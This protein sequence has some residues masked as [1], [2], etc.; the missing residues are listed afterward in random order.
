M[1]AN[2]RMKN[3]LEKRKK[4]KSVD[5]H[6]VEVVDV[7]TIVVFDILINQNALR[8]NLIAKV[9]LTEFA[10]S[11]RFFIN[12]SYLIVFAKLRANRQLLI[13]NNDVEK[14]L[15]NSQNELFNLNFLT[16]IVIAHVSRIITKIFKN[17]QHFIKVIE[18]NIV[19]VNVLKI[20]KLSFNWLRDQ[21]WC[22][23]TA[24]IEINERYNKNLQ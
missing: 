8:S 19:N 5:V 15:W 10:K 20:D 9:V 17:S 2:D 24:K 6:A 13:V 22:I 7:Q 21:C 1:F 3:S 16:I 4:K 23:S 14:Q 12:V 11:W 18:R